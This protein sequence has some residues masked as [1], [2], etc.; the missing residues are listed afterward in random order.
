MC[1]SD[2]DQSGSAAR[3]ITVK[4]TCSHKPVV[5]MISNSSHEPA[6]KVKMR[7]SDAAQEPVKISPPAGDIK[8]LHEFERKQKIL[9]EEI[10]SNERK[11]NTTV[12]PDSVKKA[13][14]F[15]LK[16]KQ[17]F[18]NMKKEKTEETTKEKVDSKDSNSYNDVF[19]EYLANK[20]RNCFPFVAFFTFLVYY[21]SYLLL[22]FFACTSA[23][24]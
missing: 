19:S 18:K 2:L 20:A 15:M 9:I 8:S 6:P 1:S 22:P 4:N 11:Q 24:R 16:N 13:N 12:S 23:V 3:I 7:I 14:K 10:V 21:T 17:R 5:K